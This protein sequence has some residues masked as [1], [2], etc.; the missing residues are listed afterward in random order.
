MSSFT[1]VLNISRTLSFFIRSTFVLYIQ[2]VALFVGA[3]GWDGM[4]WDGMSRLE[5]IGMGTGIAKGCLRE[6]QRERGRG[7]C[8]Q[9]EAEDMDKIVFNITQYPIIMITT[10]V[11]FSCDHS[12]QWYASSLKFDVNTS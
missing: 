7:G 3:V 11:F 9:G 6:R 8:Q 12:K 2:V 1:A 10:N 4:G 5:T